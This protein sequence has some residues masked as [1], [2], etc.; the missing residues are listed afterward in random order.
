MVC[1]GGSA[2]RIA[3]ALHI[4]PEQ[5][6]DLLDKYFSLFP[7]LKLYL[8]N[9][10]TL[11]KYQK[12]VQCKLTNRVYFVAESNA[13]GDNDDNAACRKAQNSLIQGAAS[14]ITKKALWYV[15]N[16]FDELNAKYS[17]DIPEG[18]DAALCGVIHD[19]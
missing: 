10:G 2:H 4:E 5:S 9:T 16:S 8:D 6:Q 7:E 19:R 11:A 13:K 14:V 1:Y 12:Y 15:Q 18:K 17:A 3:N